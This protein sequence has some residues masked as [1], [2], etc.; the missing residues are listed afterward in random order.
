MTCNALSL[1]VRWSDTLS[2][3]P[4]ISTGCYPIG[5]SEPGFSHLPFSKE[6]SHSHT[7]TLSNINTL[8]NK[9]KAAEY[10]KHCWNYNRNYNYLKFGG[11][12]FPPSAGNLCCKHLL[13]GLCAAVHG[14][15]LLLICL[16][17]L[18]CLTKCLILYARST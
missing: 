13:I 4:S 8:L 16:Y 15:N 11:F 1:S 6:A 5:L 9:T 3:W 10:D 17:F 14:I 2:Q 12:I 7:H 18:S